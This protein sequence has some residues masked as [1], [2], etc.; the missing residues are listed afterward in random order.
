MNEEVPISDL[1]GFLRAR[2]QG[3][4]PQEVG[5]NSSGDRRVLGLRREEVADLAGV[6]ED[7]Y[8]R[9]EQGRERH[10]SEQ[11]LA[12]LAR[13]LNLDPHA[14]RHL[15]EIVSPRRHP[16]E[17][18]SPTEISEG[19]RLLLEHALVV[20]ASVIGPASDVLALNAL[21]AALYSPFARVDNLAMM[22]FLDSAARDFYP[23]WEAV[24]RTSVANL[25]DAS[26][27]FPREPRVAEV[28]GELSMESAR[29]ASLWAEYEVRPRVEAEEVFRHPV[30][31]ELR[32]KFEAL[33][34]SGVPGQ[35]I[36]VYTPMPDTPGSEK[37][38]ALA[39]SCDRDEKTSYPV[40]LVAPPIDHDRLRPVLRL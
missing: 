14:S 28:I 19:V 2:R 7:Y 29:F 23:D 25:R 36:Y 26:T 35:R 40:E 17:T 32:L 21:A 15:Y 6:S 31:G 10:P 5:L 3:L 1:G 27:Q 13:A 34:I 38:S 11:V 18:R 30:A 37:L 24:A 16:A 8:R 39:E 12:A 33:S 9:L 22:V 20:P 4:S